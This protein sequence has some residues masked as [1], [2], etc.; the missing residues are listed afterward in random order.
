MR[1]L[2]FL[3]FSLGIYLNNQQPESPHGADFKIS[4]KTC[5]STKGWQ[6]DKAIYSFDHNTTLLPLEGQHKNLSCRQCHPTLKFGEAKTSC[7]ECHTDIHQG[8]VGFDCSRCHTPASWLVNN[9][10]ELHQTSRFPLVGAHRTADCSQCHLSESL[11]RFDVQG[12]NCIDCHRKDYLATTNPN[13]QQSGISEDCSLCHQVTSFEWTSAGFDHS[14]FPLQL[15]HSSLKCNDCHTTGN[16]ADAKP[17]CISCHQQNYTATTNPDHQAAQ[18]STRCLDCH[19]LNPGWKPTNYNHSSFPLE[20]A[21]SVPTC[22][23]CHTKGNYL[24]TSPECYSCHEQNY[25]A[26]TNPNHVTSGFPKACETCHSVSAGWKPV[27][28]D[29]SAFPLNLGHSVVACTDC[30]K[31]ANYSATPVACYSCHSQD[32]NATTNPNHVESG[33]AKTCENCHSLNPGWTPAGFNHANFPLTL[34]HSVPTCADCHTGGN[35]TNLSADCYSCHQANFNSTTNPNHAASGFPTTCGTCHTLNPG[36]TPATFSH[37]SFPL[38]LGH[39]TPTCTDCHN[40]NYTNLSSDCYSCH[41]QNYTATTNPNHVSAGFPTT[42]STCHTLNPGWTPATYNHTSFPLTLGHST[43]TCTDCHNGNYSNLSSD[44]YSCHQQNY[45][46]T[47]NPNHVSAGFP[48]T[49]STCHTLNPGW[50]PATFN[51]TSFPL[52]LGHSTPTCT[53][54]HKVNYTNTSAAC[55]SCHATDFNNTTNPNHQSLGFATSCS[56]C[57][58]TAAGWKP[59]TFAAHESLFPIASGRHKLDCIECH[60]NPANYTL[61]DCKHCHTDAHRSNN[62]TNADCY[63]CHPTGRAG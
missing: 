37:T 17:E 39:S 7:N 45:T 11:L 33:I 14:I 56:D 35:Y 40:G 52:T 28:I 15:G 57:H 59:A 10:I 36:W 34:G 22:N 21:H 46:A 9:I 16:F 60:T 38:T 26:T 53:D 47:T 20:Q 48:T 42:C 25:A 5:H 30:H 27:S 62:Y 54:C 29:H 58:T 51:H 63:R 61:F 24:S 12:I 50:T 23:D 4:C 1:I 19:T 49:C 3:I 8:T 43:P 32:Y 13:H 55:Y 41:Q 2:S 18:F 44:C 6:L 31:D